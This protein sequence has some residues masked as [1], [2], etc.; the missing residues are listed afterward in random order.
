MQEAND[1]L[2]DLNNYTEI[3]IPFRKSEYFLSLMQR[4]LY[5]FVGTKK[6]L[7]EKET[8]LNL[9]SIEMFKEIKV[10]EMLKVEQ[11]ENNSKMT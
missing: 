1:R 10:K 3:S 4:E 9:K 7:M 8:E 5:S 6:Q 11:K 2:K